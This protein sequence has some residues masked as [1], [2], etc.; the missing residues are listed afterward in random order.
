MM[1]MMMMMMIVWIGLL[2]KG[3]TRS[4]TPIDSASAS[5]KPTLLLSF[6]TRLFPSV[7]MR[8]TMTMM[9]LRA[10]F[11]IHTIL[12]LES[13][14]NASK[15]NIM[16][17]D[18]QIVEILTPGAKTL[19]ECETEMTNLNTQTHIPAFKSCVCLRHKMLFGSSCLSKSVSQYVACLS[20][21]INSS[22]AS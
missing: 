10:L 4:G 19:Q 21:I 16:D 6:D 13:Y 3:Y 12:K 15:E 14:G 2:M 8:S 22:S 11:C 1:M 17:D 5:T 9:R 20:Q 7:M 18:W